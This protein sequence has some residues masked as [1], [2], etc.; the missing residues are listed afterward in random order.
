MPKKSKK[1][2]KKYSNKKSKI[3][4]KKIYKKKK[5]DKKKKLT[6]KVKKGGGLFPLDAWKRP[7]NGSNKRL[8]FDIP[9]NNMYTYPQK[10]WNGENQMYTPSRSDP[11]NSN[12]Q[13][14]HL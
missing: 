9:K 6:K 3:L 13:M 11:V 4:S 14:Y 10:V 8:K 12:L 5:K 1:N 2:I 7:N